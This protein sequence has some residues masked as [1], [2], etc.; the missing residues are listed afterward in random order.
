MC[1]AD[2]ESSNSP[3]PLCA[4]SAAAS[5]FEAKCSTGQQRQSLCAEEG[6]A[7]ITAALLPEIPTCN[8]YS[9][10]PRSA[11][12]GGPAAPALALRG[13]AQEPPPA[14]AAAVAAAAPF[15]QQAGENA[16]APGDLSDGISDEED[17]AVAAAA[18]AAG[19][20][21]GLEEA[22]KED[23]SGAQAGYWVAARR[24]WPSMSWAA[25][26]SSP[27]AAA[28]AALAASAAAAA[29]RGVE[30]LG[31]TADGAGFDDEDMA[32]PPLLTGCL[33]KRSQWKR[34]W[35][36]RF[37]V[38]RRRRLD[39]YLGEAEKVS[40]APRG[41]IALR[42]V[43]MENEIPD[44]PYC[45]HVDGHV[46]SCESEAQRAL[47]LQ[48]LGSALLAKRRAD[49][50]ARQALLLQAQA[51]QEE[52]RA[53]A[54]TAPASLGSHHPAA[55]ASLDCCPVESDDVS[56]H[57]PSTSSSSSS[58]PA[59]ATSRSGPLSIDACLQELAAAESTH[60][61]DSKEVVRCLRRLAMVLDCEGRGLQAIP[62]WI[63]ILE[64]RRMELGDA[65]SEVVAL[66]AWIR[67]ELE[68]AQSSEQLSKEALAAYQAM[69]EQA[70]GEA[71]AEASSEA[72]KPATTRNSLA[73]AAAFGGDLAI[74]VGAAV[75]GAMVGQAVNVGLSAV[76]C[77]ASLMANAT[78]SVIGMAARSAVGSL[79]GASAA[80]AAG[81]GAGAA[82]GAAVGAE[83]AGA[84]GA[85]AAQSGWAA[86][87][88][89]AAGNVALGGARVVAGSAL[90]AAQQAGVGISSAAATTALS[91]A[92][93][94]AV[95]TSSAAVSGTYGVIRRSVN[96]MREASISEE[97]E[98]APEEEAPVA[99]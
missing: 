5:E 39:Y 89:G 91:L 54:E 2:A 97:A 75:G 94:A 31:S 59:G 15:Q 22:P 7:S 26:M 36:S 47:W 96:Y 12:E 48:A 63:R 8:G 20:H 61:A 95:A 86:A 92:G 51:E 10:C 84:V 78:G 1:S 33:T 49:D 85:A 99:A 70:E 93:R 58:Q 41:S 52:G 4:E 83:A 98:T 77:T 38:L 45:F 3:S 67:S 11:D 44:R 28:A 18:P 74:G 29:G 30:A 6:E 32:A 60:G 21:G 90:G 65:H 56:T 42:E 40:D 27:V 34:E 35:T 87:A 23:P 69:L 16:A 64:I 72:T 82:A 62:L 24:T 88:A 55:E 25:S 73:V 50:E 43:H 57:H 13:C 76:T 46:L 17:A 71:P 14:Q 80:G 37:F 53:R 9:M 66:R 79:A 81:A 68:S 19:G